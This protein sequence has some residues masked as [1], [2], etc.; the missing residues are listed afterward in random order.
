MERALATPHFDLLP[1]QDRQ[2]FCGGFI[3]VRRALPEDAKAGKA[4]APLYMVELPHCVGMN[5]QATKVWDANT[6]YLLMTWVYWMFWLATCVKRSYLWDHL[7]PFQFA[8]PI[9]LW[10]SAI[11]HNVLYQ[12]TT[13]AP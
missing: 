9:L 12:H 3:V 2:E 11:K 6:I 7:G 5:G 1:G 4:E 8:S 10:S 13:T